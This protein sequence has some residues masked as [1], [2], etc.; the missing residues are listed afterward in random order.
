M[1]SCEA[2]AAPGRKEV[3]DEAIFLRRYVREEKMP[4]L[5]LRESNQWVRLGAFSMSVIQLVR[6]AL[7]PPTLPFSCCVF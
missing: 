1:A 4:W 2:G 7:Q 6:E 3:K 5:L